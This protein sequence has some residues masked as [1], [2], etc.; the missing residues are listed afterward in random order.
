LSQS[1]LIGKDVGGVFLV[2]MDGVR[3]SFA[4][5]VRMAKK[6]KRPQRSSLGKS[7]AAFK[8]RNNG[9]KEAARVHLLEQSIRGSTS[10]SY[11]TPLGHYQQLHGRLDREHP[12]TA[13]K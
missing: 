1:G 6:G 8:L 2:E 10:R 11:E 3:C 12:L 7:I 9:E 5:F 13:D 4:P